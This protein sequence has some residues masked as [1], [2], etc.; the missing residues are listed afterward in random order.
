MRAVGS[1][2]ADVR[3]D[4]LGPLKVTGPDGPVAVPVGRTAAVLAWLV[5]HADAPVSLSGIAEAVW[6]GPE[7]IGRAAA[8]VRTLHR[9][10]GDVVEVG[11][12]SRL[13]V[14]PEQV[15]A[16]CFERLVEEGHHLLD[17]DHERAG[18][19]LREALS[20][21]RGEPFPEL[22]R[23]VGIVG[24]IDRLT[25][26]Q[27]TAVEEL[28]GI[29]LRGRV[30]YQLVAQ[31][32]AEVI[33]H[34]ERPR[35]RRQLSIALYRTGRQTEALSTLEEARRELPDPSYAGLLAALL[36][37]APELQSGEI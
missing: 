31:L 17:S 23:A 1:R 30:D 2:L 21:W 14:E 35:L 6:G 27:L 4:V 34:P 18:R 13:R 22:D 3:F 29:A 33:L 28:A 20:L 32:R 36:Q 16:H 24:E 37:N 11:E 25:E 8:A 26:V 5:A 7:G 9:L 10:L 12:R 15:D 19:C